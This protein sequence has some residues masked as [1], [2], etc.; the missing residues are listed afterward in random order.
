M[1]EIDKIA[2]KHLGKKSNGDINKNY[3]SQSKIEESLLVCIPRALNR[4]HDNI[5]S[6]KLPFLGWDVWHA[7]EFSFLL[8]NSYPVTGL[9]KIIYPCESPNIVE[10]KSL[11]LFLN[12]FNFVKFEGDYESAKKKATN[13]VIEILSKLLKTEVNASF[14]D[15]NTLEPKNIFNDFTPLEDSID[16]E[17]EDFNIFEQNSSLLQTKQITKPTDFRVSSKALRSNCRVTNQ[18]DW[19]DIFIKI[20]GNQVPTKLSLL[21]F[22]ISMRQENHFHEEICE[23]VFKTLF[24]LLPNSKILVACLYTRRGGIDINPIRISD[25]SLLDEASFLNSLLDLKTPFSKT[26]RQ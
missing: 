24:D 8:S 1:D 25:K 20:I 4:E 19:G 18:P 6:E 23:H 14:H 17:N 10:S 15:K 3:Q 16:F 12:S 26:F 22:I 5:E 13:K 21:K 2:S 11:K 9:L 7:F